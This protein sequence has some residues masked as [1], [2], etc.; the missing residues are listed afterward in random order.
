L[1]KKYAQF[2]TLNRL[3]PTAADES[4]PL[5]VALCV[6]VVVMRMEL[7]VMTRLISTA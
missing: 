1:R 5:D 4:H 2:A 7:R 3:A 6:G